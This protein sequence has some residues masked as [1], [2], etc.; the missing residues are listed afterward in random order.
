LLL[1]FLLKIAAVGVNVSLVILCLHGEVIEGNE[2]GVEALVLAVSHCLYVIGE[3]VGALYGAV[4]GGGGYGKTCVELIAA[5]GHG[6]GVV[7]VYLAVNYGVGYAVYCYGA[8][9]V[10]DEV[11]N[12]LIIVGEGECRAVDSYVKVGI[13][14]A[15]NDGIL[16]EFAC[17][18]KG[19]GVVCICNE[20]CEVCIL[21][22]GEGVSRL[23][24]LNCGGNQSLGFGE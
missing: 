14:I 23:N 2:E 8:G 9:V 7:A 3:G 12:V 21:N 18:S 20:G 1:S 22:L 19:C 5:Q 16:G 24:V 4:L 10:I 13:V 15:R 6:D 11:Y 17:V